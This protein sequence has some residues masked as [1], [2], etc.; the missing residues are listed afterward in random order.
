MTVQGPVKEQQP[1]GMS[2]RGGL[3]D[4]HFSDLSCPF[5][6]SHKHALRGSITLILNHH[7]YLSYLFQAGQGPHWVKRRP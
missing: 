6:V 5:D 2:H 7:R 1:D 3:R 4:S